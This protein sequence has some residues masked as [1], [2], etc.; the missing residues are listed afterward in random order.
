MMVGPLLMIVGGSELPWQAFQSQLLPHDGSQKSPGHQFNPGSAWAS[1]A[2]P[3][4][5][6][7]NAAATA[8]DAIAQLAN[9]FMSHAYRAGLCGFQM[10]AVRQMRVLVQVWQVGHQNRLRPSSSAV[11]TE[12]PHTRHG[13]PARR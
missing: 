10:D 9:F 8:A 2:P 3:R 4:P 6:N 1:G 12:V 11:R 5:A 7:P 13:S